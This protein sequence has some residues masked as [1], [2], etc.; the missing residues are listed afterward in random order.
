[1]KLY[2]A[3]I[4]ISLS[5]TAQPTSG[6]R[7]EALRCE[8]LTNPMGIDVA[9]PRLS[10]RLAPLSPGL[11]QSAYQIQ[12][13][14]S[15]GPLNQGKADIWDS[16]R[17]ASPQTAFIPYQGPA[18]VSGQRLTWRVR[19]WDAAGK[20]SAWS[21]H[22]SWSMGLLKPEDWTA[23]FIGA[24]LQQDAKPG[25]PQP[26]PWLRKTFSL[27][28]KAT[29]ATAYVNAL[30]YYELYVNG[31]KIDDHLLSP[32]VTDYSKRNLYVTHDITS[33]LRPGRNVIALWLGRGWYVRGH[34]GV[35]HDGPLVRARFD[36][37]QPAGAPVRIETEASWKVRFSPI[38]PLGRGTAFGDYGGERYDASLEVP[39]WNSTAFDDSSWQP[40][41]VFNPPVSRT[42]AQMVQ[43]NRAIETL[44]P[45]KIEETAP[46]TYTI[47][48][49]RNYVGW[50]DVKLPPST[51]AGK[52]I[53][54]EFADTPPATTRFMTQNQRDEYVTRAGAGQTIRS[55]F[56]YHGFRWARITGLDSAPTASDITARLIRTDYARASTFESSDDL[57]NR[58]YR[59]A[60]WTYE[61]LSLG[62]YVV[63]CPTRE[64]LG[65]GGDAGTS[66][67]TGLF[68]FDTGGLYNNW[69]ANWRDAQ[70][71]NGDVP[72]TAPNY[73]DQG[74]GGP[75]WS[76]FV[77]TLPW[78][79]YLQY[80]DKRALETN[81]NLIRNWLAF[82]DTKTKD[83][84]IEH[85][86]SV[87]ISMPQWNYLGDWVAPRR[88][89]DQPDIARNPISSRFINNCHYLYTLQLA[90]RIAALLNKPEDSKLYTARAAALS[91]KL[92][93]TF[94]N[95]ADTTYATGEQPYLAFPLLI[96]VAPQNLRV[97]LM[98]NLEQT[99]RVKDA[100]HINAG[101]HGVYFLL[102]YLMEEDRNDLIYEMTSKT[103]FP[104]W[105]NM[106][107]QGATT[108]WESWSGQSR[109]H[110]TLISIGAWFIEG[111]GGIRID[112]QAP[113]FSH[114]FLKPAPVGNL[115]FARTT[116]NSIHGDIVSNWRIENGVLHYDATVPPGAT[117]TL[118]LPAAPVATPPPGAKFTRVE[119][120]KAL[121][122]LGPGTYSFASKRQ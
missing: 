101:M 89:R 61:N 27:D 84:L 46:G 92:H 29:R 88:S 119:K 49:G 75:M 35:I 91:R 86:V 103:T 112:E 110:D 59:T 5:A 11:R 108:F 16:G 64:R 63:D 31:A 3:L 30:G 97:P 23:P 83:L 73:P 77:V 34:P 107:E 45:A 122:E 43:P 51:A 116:Y 56:N 17:I 52:Q 44:H 111:I 33:H 18:L 53:R 117:A 74:G 19:A 41:A 114:F 72:Y 71:P 38:T 21:V 93:E 67:E 13:A 100:G 98:K 106:L 15:S 7:P 118:H 42:T 81:Y 65:Y 40:A 69:S 94:F 39:N 36:I 6:F 80:G 66:I 113:G 47:D 50:F 115:T 22:A 121:Y 1:M 4:L 9:Q 54:I 12:V 79:I 48:M 105:G 28:R 120:G 8:Y 26:F 104:G 62:G 57:L 82:A 24:A 60:N 109:I 85:Y 102:K 2:L 14:S 37:D 68:N 95:A 32:A 76:G 87:G 70:A 20:P 58:I 90:S 96:G 10:W 78:H 99:I 55:R 25:T